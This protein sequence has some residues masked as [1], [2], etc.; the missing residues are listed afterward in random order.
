MKYFDFDFFPQLIKNVKTIL[1]IQKQVV[2]WI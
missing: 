2:S 1:A